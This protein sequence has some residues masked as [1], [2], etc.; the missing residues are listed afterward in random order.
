V[1]FA[2]AWIQAIAGYIAHVMYKR[3]G[4]STAVGRVHVWAGRV[5][6]TIGMINGGLGLLLSADGTRSDYI[7]YGVVA[8]SIWVLFGGVS[9]HRDWSRARSIS[10]G[11]KDTPDQL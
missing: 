1:I 10:V 11:E 2:C 3:R 8:G 9:A 7:A 6:I 4:M 5:L